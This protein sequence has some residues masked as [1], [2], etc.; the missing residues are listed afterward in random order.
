MPTLTA[1]SRKRMTARIPTGMRS[2][3][4]AAAELS[5]ATVNQFI[6]QAAYREAQRIVERETVI[7]LSQQDARQVLS[8]LEAPPKPNR[9]LKEAVAAFKRLGHA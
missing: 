8:L 4:E 6:V 7:R 1:D 3:L 2:T 5:G 9:R